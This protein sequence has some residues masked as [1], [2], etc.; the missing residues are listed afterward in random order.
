MRRA[1]AGMLLEFELKSMSV[2]PFQAAGKA[3][4]IA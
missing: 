4:V 3:A 1:D 2:N